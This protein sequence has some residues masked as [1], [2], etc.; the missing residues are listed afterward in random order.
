MG[1][2]AFGL[3]GQ[4]QLP[5]FTSKRGNARFIFFFY[6]YQSISVWEGEFCPVISVIIF[7]EIPILMSTS[8]NRGSAPILKVN[9][10]YYL[11][12]N[13]TTKPQTTTIWV[14]PGIWEHLYITIF[15]QSLSQYPTLEQL[16]IPCLYLE[17]HHFSCRTSL[18]QTGAPMVWNNTIHFSYSAAF[19]PR[20]TNLALPCLA[21]LLK[22]GIPGSSCDHMHWAH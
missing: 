16:H 12:K 19:T 13:Q 1:N 22:T 14:A 21:L 10:V 5:L 18:A 17:R 7:P 4:K 11:K 3:E 9:H 6:S 15:S 8:N 20:P 2:C